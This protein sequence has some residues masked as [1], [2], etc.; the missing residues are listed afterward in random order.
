MRLIVVDTTGI[1]PYIFGS[2]RL[3][4]NIGASHL[5]A[6]ATGRWAL[7][8]VREWRSNVLA[9]GQLEDKR[10][11]ESG[12][13]DA[14]VVYSGGGNFVVLFGD[15]CDGLA[16]SFARKLS[17]R[18]L[19]EAP[20]LQI[21]MANREFGWNEPLAVALPLALQ[22]LKIRKN[23][24]S[25]TLPMA[26][27]GVTVPCQSTGLPAVRISDTIGGDAGYPISAEIEAKLE[28]AGAAGDRLREMLPLSSEYCYPSEFDHLGR[29]RSDFS[30][31]AVVHADG[32]GIGKRIKGLGDSHQTA[33]GNREFIRQI[34]RFSGA[35]ETASLG[36]L[37]GSLDALIGRIIDGQV[38]HGREKLMKFG[39]T[40]VAGSSEIRLPFR[41]IVFG[42]DDLTFV[43]D[44]RLGLSLTIEYLKLFNQLTE[45]L[46][47][48]GGAATASA[49]VAIVK[50]HYPFAR[51]YRLAEELCHS[52]K[53][54]KPES[55]YAGTRL[56]WHFATGGLFGGINEIRDREYAAAAGTLTLR[57]LT[58]QE[59]PY[60]QLRSWSVVEKGISE[61]QAAGW[62]ERRNK[63]KALRDA[64][65]EGRSTVESF[66]VKYN[67]NRELP[68]VCPILDGIRRNGWYGDLCG[69]FD[70]IEMID[71]YY[72]L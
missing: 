15:N 55:E 68:D 30:Y 59:N 13:I 36:A 11:I 56:D 70:A 14:E 46:P 33:S 38:T 24:R 48:G 25:L 1:Q 34:R 18:V 2:N 35:I 50:S 41:P 17:R 49:G 32:N 37:K 53:S 44:G 62:T 39:L 20:G 7:D 42:G 31:I 54:Y 51:A 10:Q 12:E 71:W 22:D 66:L 43:C 23:S 60:D 29:S 69:Y 47:D 65:R 21:V 5:V 4:E 52:A 72:A 45:N 19:T 16:Q 26:G 63:V 3:R 40:E 58:L 6:Q 9:D 64:L 67:G 57:P 28:Q 27:L 8:I 61:F